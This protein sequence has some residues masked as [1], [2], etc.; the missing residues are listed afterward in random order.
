[1]GGKPTCGTSPGPTT[2][3]VIS[4]AAPF[5]DTS[6]QAIEINGLSAES[7]AYQK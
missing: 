2:K 7:E 5:F 4:L 3:V 1:V 6:D